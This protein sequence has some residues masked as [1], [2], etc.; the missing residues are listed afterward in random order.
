MSRGNQRAAQCVQHGVHRRYSGV[1]AEIPAPVVLPPAG[2]DEAR[3]RLIRDLDVRVGFCVLELD[4]VLG[5]VL[6]N[7]R[8]FQRQRLNLRLA[9]EVIEVMYSCHHA[10]GLDVLLAVLEILRHPIVQFARLPD[11]NNPPVPI[12]HDVNAGSQRE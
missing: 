5:R 6:F 11:V 4:V 3:V 9:K 1:G 7:E 2:H 10:R 12:L 8:V